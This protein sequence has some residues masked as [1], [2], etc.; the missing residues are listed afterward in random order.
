MIFSVEIDYFS[1]CLYGIIIVGFVSF[2]VLVLL[3]WSKHCFV[4]RDFPAVLLS[5]AAASLILTVSDML[6]FGN[7]SG[8]IVSELGFTVMPLFSMYFYDNSRKV[9]RM[10]SCALIL[11]T[12][13]SFAARTA[14]RSVIGVW[15]MIGIGFILLGV[16]LAIFTIAAG[17]FAKL[18][19]CDKIHCAYSSEVMTGRVNMI[20]LML[21]MMLQIMGVQIGA[22][23]NAFSVVVICMCILILLS[24]YA[25]IYYR[26]TTGKMFF[27]IKLQEGFSGM[28]STV[29]TVG[30]T[31]DAG[32]ADDESYGLIYE[33]L[34][35]YFEESKPFLDGNLGISDVAKA[36]FTNKAYLS[37]S[38]NMYAGRNFCQYVN[39]FRIKYSIECFTE[40][41]TLRIAALAQMSGFNSTT[42]FNMAFKLYMNEAPSEWC[43]RN[44]DM[45]CVK[46]LKK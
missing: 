38:I 27:L 23:R 43:R 6:C 2:S 1:W 15:E 30:Q 33:R 9:S 10:Y 21:I 8:Y 25:G 32:R 17:I 35:M 16:L 7:V 39:Y 36:L 20:Y 29:E 44:R 24:L 46:G 40:D 42:S 34:G 5:S 3:K 14:V 19:A 11:L 31:E 26:Y 28:P 13:S 22:S 45:L 41:P 12:L 18:S 37:R 4:C